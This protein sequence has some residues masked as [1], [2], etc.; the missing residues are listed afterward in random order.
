MMTAVSLLL[1]RF[2]KRVPAGATG[3]SILKLPLSDV[4]GCSRRLLTK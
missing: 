2:T 1:R 3:A 4:G